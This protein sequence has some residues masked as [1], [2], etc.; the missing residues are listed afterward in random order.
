MLKKI[1]LLM[2][3]ALAGCVGTDYIA[4]PLMLQPARILVTPE[5]QALEV[6]KAVQFQA[7][8]F[9]SLGNKA[10]GLAF[11]WSSSD[12][13][14][15]A[16]DA[17]GN[18]RALKVGQ[19]RITAQA[20]NLASAPAL[21]TVVADPN[22]VATVEV[23]PSSHMLAPGSTLQF[24]ATARNLNGAVISGKTFTWR[25]SNPVI[26][27]VNADGLLT[28]L[29]AGEVQ[30][31]AKVEG[32]SSP[33]VLVTVTSTSRTGTF[34]KNPSTSYNVSGTAT[35]ERQTNGALVLRFSDTFSSSNGPGL[36]VILSTTKTAGA[37]SVNLG[38]LQKTS[39]A[40]TYNVSN[41]VTLT[42]HDWVIIHCV[43]F[44]VSFGYAQLQ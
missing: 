44:N 41:A 22:Q 6:G 38:R 20:R 3:A 25:S 14:L 16:I 27:S 35:L 36:E 9:D 1:L 12:P 10:E 8:Y 26:A 40:Q 34:T 15:V 43:P 33:N 23:S 32:V 21:L 37:N 39:G 4:D 7:T 28:A 18:A 13:T 24:S 2:I 11:S 5:V 31:T 19:A 30:I 29:V 42:S 17:N